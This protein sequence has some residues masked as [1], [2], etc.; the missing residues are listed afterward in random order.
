[1]RFD[2][3]WDEY[4]RLFSG[5]SLWVTLHKLFAFM[6]SEK[7]QGVRAV[8]LVGARPSLLAFSSASCSWYFSVL[9]FF[10]PW[11][12][13]DTLQPNIYC[14]L[15][16][17][18]SNLLYRRSA[19]GEHRRAVP[20]WPHYGQIKVE[21][22]DMFWLGKKNF[23]SPISKYQCQP[24][25]RQAPPTISQFEA[26]T[27]HKPRSMNDVFPPFEEIKAKKKSP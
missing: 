15:L 7:R 25:H 16:C 27:Y 13:P 3:V 6:T 8:T 1:M 12:F 22:S 23:T 26:G 4:P 11:C 21:C 14:S 18:S 9:F 2:V 10:L 5:L 20:S 17:F 24:S 19:P